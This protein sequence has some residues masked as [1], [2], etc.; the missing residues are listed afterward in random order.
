MI[1]FEYYNPAKIVFGEESEKSLKGLLEKHNVK[2][3]LLVYSGDFIKTRVIFSV[4]E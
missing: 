2:S 1:G 3:L 4:I